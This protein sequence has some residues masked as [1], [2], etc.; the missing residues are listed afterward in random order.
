M[1]L[2][3]IRHGQTD[4]NA[5][6]FLQGSSDIPLN[7]TGRRQAHEAAAALG[8]GKWE[9]IVSSPLSRARETARI[10]AADLGLEL[11]R[12]YDELSERDYGQAE[13]MTLEESEKHWPNRTGGGIEPLDSVVAR[14][15]QAIDLIAAEFPG[16]N[17]A[18]VCH[19]TIIRYT[20]SSIAGYKLDQIHNGS[21]VL[22]DD[23]DGHWT[24]RSVNDQPL[25][26]GHG[27]VTGGNQH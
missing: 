7:D 14:G 15:R 25:G 22:V 13:G 3:F 2:G 11:G 26:P 18:I 4:W 24:V 9:A 27:Q 20:L 23:A 5:Q 8:H 12:S 1:E 17:V 6:D 16:K 10:M 21:V 19:G